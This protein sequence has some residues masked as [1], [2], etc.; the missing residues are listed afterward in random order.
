MNA[1]DFSVLTRADYP[2][3]IA[4]G[5]M[6]MLALTVLAWVLAMV[7]GTLLAL[8]RMTSSRVAQAGVAAWVEYHQNVPML[9]QIFL[10]YFGIATLLHA[11]VQFWVNR[12]AGEFIFAVIAV[13][14]A[15]SAYFSEDLRCGIRAIPTSQI[16]AA[17]AL[18]FSYVQSFRLVV[19]PQ[20]LRIAL[21][22]IVNHT[23][24]LF[25]NTSLAMAIGVAEL[26][27]VTREIESQSFRTVEIYLLTT[28]VYLG[29][30]LLLMAGG[31]MVERSL[32]T[33]GR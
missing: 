5:L 7:L 28:V 6:T 12:H 1:I 27:Y 20:A 19:L 26:T 25:K 14:L 24:L 30:S 9:V 3:L 8:I 21:P 29:I 13:A 10:W 11:D 17:R 16:E 15:T 33:P 18:G 2:A 4:K 32:A 23:V 31:A 22:T